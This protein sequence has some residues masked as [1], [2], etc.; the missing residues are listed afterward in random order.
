VPW[1][2]QE[3]ALI[4]GCTR[5][6]VF[7][8]IAVP[9]VSP[10]LFTVC[11]IH[12]YYIW[13]EFLFAYTFILDK[14]KWTGSVGLYS[15]IGQTMVYWR[16]MLVNAIL[17]SAIPILFYLIFRSHIVKGLAEGFISK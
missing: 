15:F 6:G 2:I 9:I 3:A 17:F 4:D 14:S 11:I 5:Y 8:R 16:E 13:N 10:A 1:E 7:Y 12:F